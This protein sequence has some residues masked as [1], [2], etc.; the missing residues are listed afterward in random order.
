MIVDVNTRALISGIAY[1]SAF[2]RQFIFN[3]L[4]GPWPW[5]YASWAHTWVFNSS[6]LSVWKH[7]GA[8]LTILNYIYLFIYFSVYLMVKFRCFWHSCFFQCLYDW[9]VHVEFRVGTGKL[10]VVC[11]IILDP[12]AHFSSFFLCN[13]FQI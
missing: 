12:H 1:S 9:E 13:G 5:N 2:T 4:P 11:Q 7:A 6:F 3:A 8:K 10:L